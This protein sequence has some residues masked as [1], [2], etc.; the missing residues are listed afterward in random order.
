[1]QTQF[2]FDF[3]TTR[4]RPLISIQK[5]NAFSL[6]YRRYGT[7]EKMASLVARQIN[8]IKTAQSRWKNTLLCSLLRK[9]GYTQR[10]PSVICCGDG[11]KRRNSNQILFSWMTPIA[12]FGLLAL[13]THT[14]DGMVSNTKHIKIYFDFN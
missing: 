4:K 9:N 12:S 1:M 5:V 2:L 13:C 8:Q 7:T 6:D 10:S 11:S 14:S 3:G